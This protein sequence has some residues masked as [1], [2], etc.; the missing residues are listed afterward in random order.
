MSDRLNETGSLSLSAWQAG[1]AD[2]ACAL[3]FYSR[4]PV[5]VLSWERNPHG[6][7]DFGRIVRI[8]PLAGFVLGLLPACAL[9][10]ALWLDLG[11]WLAAI[12]AIATATITTGAFHEDGLADTADSFGGATRERRLAIMKDSL[13]G[14]FGTCA[15]VLGFALRITALATLILRTD[16]TAVAAAVLIVAALSRVAG[17]VPLVFLPPARTDGAAQAVGQP[18]RESFWLAVALSAGLALLVGL[19]GGLPV[20]GIALMILFAGLSGIGLMRLAWRHI[21]GQTGDIAGAAQQVAEM[22]AL[23]GLLIALRP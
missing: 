6:L 21:Q 7:P 1:I 13:I 14:S 10:L 11:P 12:L 8:L 18:A 23:I 9:V 17:L 2:L 5:P 3:R 15:L 4:L 20:S 19:A 22:A 16:A